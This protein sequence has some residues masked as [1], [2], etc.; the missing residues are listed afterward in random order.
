[1]T[2]EEEEIEMPI[3]A[4]AERAI[5]KLHGRRWNGQRLKVSEKQERRDT[6]FVKQIRLRN[7]SQL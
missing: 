4:E 7:P 6:D 2:S 5:E 1:M 3:D